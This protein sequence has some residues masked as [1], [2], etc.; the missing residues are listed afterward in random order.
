MKPAAFLLCLLFLAVGAPARASAIDCSR[1]ASQLERQVCGDPEMREYDRRI[2]AA[3][4]RALAIWDGAIGIY[5]RRDQQQWLTGFQAIERLDGAIETQCVLSD[6]DCVRDELRRRVDE[7]ESGAYVHSG[8]YRAA[9]GMKLLLYPGLANG[10]RIRIYDPARSA[11]VNIVTL[12]QDS[13]ALWDGPNGMVSR[14]GDAD[15]L[16]LPDGDGCSLR[17]QPEPLA[18][19]VVQAGGCQGQGFGGVYGRQ[20]DETLRSYDLELH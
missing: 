19:R 4:G 8:I 15:G 16:P 13:A 3:Y 7:V 20:L 2:A 10:Y 6:R 11:K 14:M 17:L 12:V 18:I 9:N 5:V 1:A